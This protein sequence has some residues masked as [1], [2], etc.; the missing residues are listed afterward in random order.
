MAD[1]VAVLADAV[2]DELAQG[3]GALGDVHWVGGSRENVFG[4]VG[5]DLD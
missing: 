2:E 3:F 4:V 5:H 1:G